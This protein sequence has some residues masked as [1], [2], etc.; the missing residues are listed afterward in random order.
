MKFG[1]TGGESKATLGNDSQIFT[2]VVLF[3]K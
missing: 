3:L 1:V 2:C